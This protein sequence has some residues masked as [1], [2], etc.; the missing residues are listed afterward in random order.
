MG[1]APLGQGG[2]VGSKPRFL[3]P[4]YYLINDTF[5]TAR[6]AGAVNGTR[7]E[8]GPGVRT[9]TDGNSKLSISG[10]A[11]VFATGGVGAGDPGLYYGGFTRVAGLIVLMA[12]TPSAANFQVGWET[13]RIASIGHGWRFAGS[14]T[15]QAFVNG[16][17]LTV[18]AWAANAQ[19]IAIAARVSG[20]FFFLKPNGG[21]WTLYWIST[22][23]SQATLLP[24]AVAEISAG[25]A[26]PD[27][28]LVPAALWLPAPLASD[29]FSVWGTT[30]GQ[31]HAEGVAG[32]VGAGGLGR[33][34][35]ANVGS[36]SVS[37]GAAVASLTGGR[38][39]ATVDCGKADVIV[40]AKL[41]GGANSA[42]V[43]ARYTSESDYVE[44][45][46]TGANV[47]LV[48]V[49]ATANTTL[50]N[51]AISFVAGAEIRLI[52]D[53]QKFRAFYNDAAVGSEQTIADA[54]LASGTKVGLRSANASNT[55]DDFR[56]Y[57]RGAGGEYALLDNAPSLT[58]DYLFV[59]GD[60]KSTDEWNGSSNWIV[61]LLAELGARTGKSWRE[62][63]P[64]YGLSGYAVSGMKLYIDSNLANVVGTPSKVCVNIG[65]NDI[66]ANTT[67]DAT[68]WK[69]NLTS[70]IDSLRAKWPSADIYVAKPWR[71]G[72][73]SAAT[74][75]AGYVD[76]VV[77][78]Y[79]S[80]V[81]VGHNESVW[82]K[83]GDN[84]AAM[85]LD[86]V[87]YNTTTA[88]TIAAAQ[89]LAAMGY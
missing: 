56:V 76:A 22:S 40:T 25:A 35:T 68:T 78:T 41:T 38:A 71:Q 26:S 46:H 70:I 79:G 33:L 4:P 24:S 72:S 81:F 10:G 69:A 58:S 44:L 7:A 80:H 61:K 67:P 8:P 89:W 47:Q 32:G 85:L 84:G 54:S 53:G 65:T 86:T 34:W 88:Q 39:I 5:T 11:A 31:G 27:R 23:G 42:A 2:A 36:W 74:A 63:Q 49:V 64:R 29:G 6:S 48:K 21:N 87:H 73:D 51:T 13:N 55:F 62:I 52:C 57:A 82:V 37:G 77:A 14:N 60:S 59:V 50:I 43:L 16:S 30:D 19:D 28:V 1:K 45:R 83:G 15:L 75:V 9:A 66:A 20:C 3:G 17:P 12:L 18:G